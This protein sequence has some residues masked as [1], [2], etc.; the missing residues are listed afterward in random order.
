M[1]CVVK[2]MC[3]QGSALSCHCFVEVFI[4][5]DCWLVGT[6]SSYSP[7]VRGNA[8][9]RVSTARPASYQAQPSPASQL[10]SARS[11]LYQAQ[12]S[13]AS[14]LSLARPAS[15]EVQPSPASQLS[16][17]RPASREARAQSAEP[18]SSFWTLTPTELVFVAQPGI[19]WQLCR[20]RLDIVYSGQFQPVVFIFF[21]GMDQTSSKHHTPKLS[22]MNGT[23]L[24]TVI[25]WMCGFMMTEIP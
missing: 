4:S 19:H 1:C 5:A 23:D 20:F 16:S 22:T 11:A 25:K 12:P 9:P 3:C 10:S 13:P 15:Y 21:S 6:S 24:F 17:A 8:A 18:P 14:Q 7:P 2:C